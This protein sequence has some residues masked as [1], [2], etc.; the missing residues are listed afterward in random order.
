M[1]GKQTSLLGPC[2]SARSPAKRP[3]PSQGRQLQ[4]PSKRR[5][6]D[7]GAHNTRSR[8]AQQG[9]ACPAAGSKAKDLVSDSEE[10]DIVV[11]LSDDDSAD[12]EE[13]PES[14]TEQPGPSQRPNHTAGM[15]LEYLHS[16][17]L[18]WSSVVSSSLSRGCESGCCLLTHQGCPPMPQAFG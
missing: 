1:T 13:E 15:Q 17:I 16:L 7:A 10:D 2:S 12:S 18:L 8:V 6:L 4:S 11:H 9:T 14:A 5:Q 3:K